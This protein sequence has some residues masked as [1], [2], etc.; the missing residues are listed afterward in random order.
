MYDFP[1]CVSF[2][3]QLNCPLF[4][5]IVAPVGGFF[6]KV[7]TTPLIDG[8]VNLTAKE[9]NFPSSIVNLPKGFIFKV[10]VGIV[11]TSLDAVLVPAA[12]IA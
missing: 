7:Y 3:V 10:V 11:V 1:P 9:S 5:L 12:F 6:S 2:G 8:S 4:W